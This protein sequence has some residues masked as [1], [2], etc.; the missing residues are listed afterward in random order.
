MMDQQVA[1]REP[2]EASKPHNLASTQDLRTARFWHMQDSQ[3]QIRARKRLSRPDAGT[4]KTVKARFGHI[5]DNQ[6]Q[7]QAHVRQSRPDSGFGFRRKSLKRGKLVPFSGCEA[8]GGGGVCA[9][10]PEPAGEPGPSLPNI[11]IRELLAP[12]I[13]QE[14]PFISF[15][16]EKNINEA[17]MGERASLVRPYRLPAQ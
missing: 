4:Y 12:K 14:I 5:K 17:I 11:D 6:G 10:Q 16:S 7:I 8:R 15:Q 3:G 2:G 13:L 1:R 9:S